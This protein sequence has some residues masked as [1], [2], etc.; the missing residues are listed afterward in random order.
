MKC[1]RVLR[2]GAFGVL[3][4][5]LSAC[6]TNDWPKEGALDLRADQIQAVDPVVTRHLKTSQ[7]W[8][9]QR[10]DISEVPTLL[11]QLAVPAKLADAVYRREFANDVEGRIKYGCAYVSEAQGFGSETPGLPEAW[12]RVRTSHLQKWGVKS[13]KAT[14]L[15]RSGKGLAFE[16]YARIGA[17]GR[18]VELVL[19]FRGTENDRAQ[20]WPDWRDNL[21]QTDFG[22]SDNVSYHG[23]RDAAKDIVNAFRD[24]LPSIKPTDACAK[25]KVVTPQLPIS[26]VG[27]SLGG[28]LAQH[29][30]YAVPACDA[31][32]AVTFN[33]SPVTGW[34]FLDRIKE[35]R[36]EDP[37]IVR[38]YN[39]REVLSF[40]RWLTTIFNFPRQN[41][42]D[43]QLAFRD[44]TSE[45][46]SM[47]FLSYW[48]D[49]QVKLLTPA[50]VGVA[51][52]ISSAVTR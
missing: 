44:F 51:G 48:I 46:H 32:G 39:D 26:F 49:R 1:M 10:V 5:A 36:N 8:N 52:E 33:T 6:A 43:Y 41:R 30:A 22:R 47:E 3:A 19:A 25:Q 27:H 29:A 15:C 23:A 12:I 4:M 50:T 14:P 40:V 20:F 18:P 21:S 17:E 13:D 28:G 42:V 11:R 7:E 35:M 38:A 16:L 45:R 24:I 2:R 31:T 9:S 37:I 34:M